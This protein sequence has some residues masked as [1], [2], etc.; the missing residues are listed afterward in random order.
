M[1]TKI[2]YLAGFM[3]SG[4]STIGP[5][6]SNVIGWLFVDLDAV[7]EQ[8]SGMTINDMFEQI[9]EE[10][11][12]KV[13]TETLIEV[14][15]LKHIIVSLGGGTLAFA[16]NYNIISKSGKIV[17]L[18]AKPETI[19]RRI[20]NKIDRP[21]FRDLVLAE[22]GEKDFLKRIV[23]LLNQRELFYNK[24]DLIINTDNIDIG[25]TVDLIANKISKWI[26]E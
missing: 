17:Y 16:D 2:I 21:L 15:K 6:L 4:K 12:R 19:Y 7:I 10:N 1:Q 24:A 11:F 9:G 14:S 25:K 8:K 13:E 20:K 3:T 5:I 26:Y 18:K 23:D 22:A